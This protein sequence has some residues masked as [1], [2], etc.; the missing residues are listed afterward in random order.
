MSIDWTRRLV[1]AAV[2]AGFP[3]LSWAQTAPVPPR[4]PSAP[5]LVPQGSPLPYALPPQPPAT[6]PGLALPQLPPAAEVAPG[7]NVRISSVTVSGATVYDRSV[8]SQITDGLTGASVPFARVEQ[9]RQD[10]LLRYRRDGYLLTNVS[11]NYDTRTGAVRLT[12]VEGYIADVKLQGD[13]GPAGTQVLRFLD[14]LL[15]ERPI[16]ISTLERYLLLASDVPGLTVRSV[17][18]PAQDDPAAVT[19][20]ATVS[21]K[22]Y[23]GTVIAD[24]RAYRLTGPE[25]LLAVGGLNSFTQFG[26]RTEL[27]ILH[28][29]NNTQTFGQAATEFF[30]GSSGLKVRLY[31]GAGGAN[32]SDVLR[33]L[34]YDGRTRVF[35]AQASYPII[36]SRE[37]TLSA[38]LAFDAIESDI[39]T[40]TGPNNTAVRASYDSLRVF[41]TGA[42]YALQ[43]VL[44]GPSRTGTNF[45]T[46][47]LS[48]GVSG[49]GATQTGDPQA[50]RTGSRT[51]FFKFNGEISRSQT[52]FRPWQDASVS[53]YGLVGGQISNSVLPPAEKYFL[54]GI[55]YN[56]GFY[57]GEVTGDNALT[58]SIEL[59]LDT[60]VQFDLAGQPIPPVPV[61]F[62]GFYDWGET[63]ENQSRDPNRRLRSTGAGARAQ[64]TPNITTEIEAVA[65][66]TRRP[67][68]AS[69]QVLPLSGNAIYWRLV[70]RF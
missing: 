50:G 34:G 22:A 38:V 39:S 43:D 46:F 29:F 69:N 27:S 48:Q 9:A 12:V 5:E 16:R 7:Q 56:R 24:N 45:V 47:R 60:V 53:L 44:L 3:V 33:E 67:Q 62:Y 17:L 66:L 20:V 70:T 31:G 40:D 19:L 8:L 14:R 30:V 13:I 58:A 54:G 32:P 2:L 55:R 35:G 51:D 10:L 26:E 37:Q 49:L 23:D 63:W 28:A 52:L 64:L 36:R 1:V 68:S 42:D 59:R 15:E 61:Q 18:R 41:R 65:R 25:Q 11:V 21:R 57:A 6:A 4:L